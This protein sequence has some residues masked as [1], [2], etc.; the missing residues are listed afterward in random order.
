MYL[1]AFS[2]VVFL[3]MISEL[4]QLALVIA[5]FGIALGFTITCMLSAVGQPP[6][7]ETVSLIQNVPLLLNFRAVVLLVLKLP[8]MGNA[9]LMIV[10][11]PTFTDQAMLLKFEGK[12]L[13]SVSRTRLES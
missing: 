3:R 7:A 13:G 9:E 2:T 10:S 12:P 1:L 4:A 11:F 5:N 8:V 6:P